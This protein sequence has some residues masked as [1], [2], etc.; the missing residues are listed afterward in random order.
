MGDYVEERPAKHSEAQPSC[1]LF[2]SAAEN[3]AAP[4]AAGYSY[5]MCPVKKHH[6][7]STRKDKR[8]L[9]APHGISSGNG[10]KK[11]KRLFLCYFITS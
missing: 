6:L 7:F 10:R 1:N 9:Q 11:K 8:P 3:E 5:Q 2:S 4:S